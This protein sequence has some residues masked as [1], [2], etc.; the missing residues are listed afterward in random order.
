[1]EGAFGRSFVGTS[2]STSGRVGQHPPVLPHMQSHT[3]LHRT[4]APPAGSSMASTASASGASHR[5]R[6][7]QHLG[8]PLTAVATVAEEVM[9]DPVQSEKSHIQQLLNRSVRLNF[10]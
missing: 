10:A 4:V 2:P 9:A 3:I 5:R 7:L 1:M 6:G 8:Q